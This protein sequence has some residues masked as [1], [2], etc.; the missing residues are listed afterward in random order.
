[1]MYIAS[2]LVPSQSVT[3]TALICLH[4]GNK[5]SRVSPTI[6]ICSLLN[7]FRGVHIKCDN[8][9]F[10][11]DGSYMNIV[12]TNGQEEA[13]QSRKALLAFLLL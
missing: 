8:S 2:T 3:T 12:Y 11:I 7:N 1:M 10:E 6:K 9:N 4:S 13:A 5:F